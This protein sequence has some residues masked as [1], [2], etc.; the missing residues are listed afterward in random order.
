MR[1]IMDADA[2]FKASLP[3]QKAVPTWARLHAE[4]LGSSPSPS[5][6]RQSVGMAAVEA[7]QCETEGCGSEA[8]LQ[9]PTC[10]KLG[11][12]GSYFCSQ[13]LACGETHRGDGYESHPAGERGG[14]RVPRGEVGVEEVPGLPGGH[15]S[16]L[17]GQLHY[18]GV[19][20]KAVFSQQ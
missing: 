4:V 15:D 19:M 20:E 18:T 16:Q 14:L 6:P 8:K 3:V 11:I 12:Q 17:D 5:P 2:I 13:A 1:L 9:C 10:I 7:R